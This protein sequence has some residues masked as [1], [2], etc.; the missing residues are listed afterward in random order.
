[1]DEQTVG[2]E[3]GRWLIFQTSTRVPARKKPGK[4][5]EKLFSAAA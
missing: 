2:I 4:W 3:Y 5:P 1:M